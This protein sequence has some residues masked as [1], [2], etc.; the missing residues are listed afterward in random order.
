MKDQLIEAATN[1][2][3]A[4][5]WR[6]LDTG[7]MPHMSIQDAGDLYGK[8]RE[9]GNITKTQAKFLFGI[10]FASLFSGDEWERIACIHSQPSDASEIRKGAALHKLIR[11]LYNA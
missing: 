9:S 8:M 3:I 4:E 1:G 10:M 2:N 6:I 7:Q 11:R 5:V